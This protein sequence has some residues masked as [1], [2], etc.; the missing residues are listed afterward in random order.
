[1]IGTVAVAIDTLTWKRNFAQGPSLD[2]E[3]YQL[4]TTGR[5]LAPP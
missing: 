2:K 4:M 1:M 3:L 5:E